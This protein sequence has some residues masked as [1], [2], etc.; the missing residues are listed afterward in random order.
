MPERSANTM[1]VS[2]A[3]SG[4]GLRPAYRRLRGA[5]ATTAREERPQF[6]VYELFSHRF[7][8]DKT[9]QEVNTERKKL[10]TL[11]GNFATAS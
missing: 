2:T 8:S 1:A 10:T 3:R 9:R 11:M 4:V 5:R 7:L 6:G